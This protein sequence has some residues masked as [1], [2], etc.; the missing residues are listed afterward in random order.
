MAVETYA[1]GKTKRKLRRAS[2][3]PIL[4]ALLLLLV[5]ISAASLALGS[6][7]IPLEETFQALT[8]YNP[9]LDSHLIV[10]ELRMPRTILA[11]LAGACLGLAGALMQSLTRNALAE[12]GTLGV[13][14][15]AATGV[16]IGNVAN[17]GPPNRTIRVDVMLIGLT[18]FN[19]AVA[20]HDDWT[21]E[22]REVS[23]LI[24]PCS[25]VV[26]HKVR[27]LAKF[28]IAMSRQHLAVGVDVNPSSLGLLQ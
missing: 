28:G 5:P 18:W 23:L 9:T 13:N 16:V 14:A 6:R 17:P 10:H 7:V 27:V 12:P 26:T 8:A 24:L 4:L 22:I 21:G 1:G 20:G 11:A 15:G 25:P 3:G 2:R 19:H